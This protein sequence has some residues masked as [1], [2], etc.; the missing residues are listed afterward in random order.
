MEKLLKLLKRLYAIVGFLHF[1]PDNYV[2]PVMRLGLY[3][4]AKGPGFAWSWPF[5]EWALPPTKTS[6][7]VVKLYLEEAVSKD[8]VPFTVRM[9]ILAT[10]DLNS[11]E[12]KIAAVLV[13]G[14]EPVIQEIV[15][16]YTNQ[17]LRRVVSRF[18]AVDLSEEG[19][20]SEIE[21]NLTR[22][23]RGELQ[24]LGIAPLPSGGVLIKEIVAPE[25]FKRG[26]LNAGR[27]AIML[28]TLTSY[29]AL[30]DLIQQAIQAGMMTGLEDL[31]DVNLALLAQS[32]NLNL[33]RTM[34]A[35]HEVPMRNGYNGSNGQNGHNRH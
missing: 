10:L 30:G 26:I 2:V 24:A 33:H 32:D 11:I 1:A 12:K 4:R 19:P 5:Y 31:D 35:I 20:R 6:L 17:G 28:Q 9:T 14:G 13:K 27:F 21:Q 29:H 22:F 34:D 25:K 16:E 23:L 8:N 7:Y 15:K 3:H 18:N